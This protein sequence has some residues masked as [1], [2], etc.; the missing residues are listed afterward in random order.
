MLEI[1]NKFNF[2]LLSAFAIP[3]II[4]I[5]FFNHELIL[6]KNNV[7]H[8]VTTGSVLSKELEYFSGNLTNI[9][10]RKSVLVTVTGGWGLEAWRTEKH[11]LYLK[12]ILNNFVSICEF[13]YNVTVVLYTY[14]GFDDWERY[15]DTSEYWCSRIKSLIN[16]QMELYELRKLS[17]RAFGTVGDLTIRHREIFLREKYNYDIFLVQEDDVNVRM[18]TLR[19]ADVWL[20]FFSGTSFH[21]SFFD[22]EIY[23]PDRYISWREKF[24]SIISYRNRLFFRRADDGCG[25]RSYAITSR[26]LQKWVSNEKE[27]IDPNRIQ[28][29][30]NPLVGSS[31]WFKDRE[32]V[33]LLI[34]IENYEWKKAAIH[35]LPNKYIRTTLNERNEV[36]S[37][38]NER[39]E[40]IKE[41]ELALIFESCFM[42]YNL[43]NNTLNVTFDGPSCIECISVR[44]QE[45]EYRAYV[46]RNSEYNLRGVNVSF[47]C[48]KKLR[49]KT[50]SVM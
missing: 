4:Y 40:M 1:K 16:I 29:E 26:L 12:I 43:L 14:E 2:V 21:P 15:I 13:G 50:K 22:L 35:H 32:K 6:L 36:R 38:E 48:V 31:C 28:G 25:G 39:F 7:H 34:P 42:N 47:K 33:H 20:D 5:Y 45:L 17:P 46:Y 44:D 49:K 9:S 27:W 41:D 23:G 37:D 24:G 3:L 18:V 8:R 30:F 10:S 19:Y 11:F